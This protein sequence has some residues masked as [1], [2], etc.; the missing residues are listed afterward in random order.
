MRVPDSRPRVLPSSMAAAHSSVAVSTPVACKH[1]ITVTAT[2]S[3]CIYSPTDEFFNLF[4]ER[5]HV[6][7]DPY[8]EG[9]ENIGITVFGGVNAP[10]V[11]LKTPGSFDSWQFFDHL[12]DKA[13]LV[14]TPGSGFGAAGEGYFRL[15]AFNSRDNV[16]EAVERLAAVV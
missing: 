10:Y 11:W 5:F 2:I 16:K 1:R 3:S 9:L 14:G 7:S 12:L 13:H 15:S 4:P 8:K 6:H